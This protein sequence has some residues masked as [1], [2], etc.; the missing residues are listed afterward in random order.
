MLLSR[1]QLDA[2]L[3][4]V[5]NQ[6]AQASIYERPHVQAVGSGRTENVN[7]GAADNRALHM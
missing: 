4:V 5:A 1:A 3:E 7:L 6:V 2:A